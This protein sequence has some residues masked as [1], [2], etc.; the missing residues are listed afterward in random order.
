[1]PRAG[2]T[3][4]RVVHE[5]AELADARGLDGLSLSALADRL[6][7][8]VPSLYKHV[9]S[10]DEVQRGV[11][12]LGIRELAAELRAA[13]VG[14]AGRDALAGCAAA[15]RSYARR[16]PGRY[17]A[18]QRV[19][20]PDAPEWLAAANDLVG[21]VFAVLR[22]YGLEDEDVVHVTRAVR[23][24]LHGFVT[25][26]LMGAFGLPEDVDASFDRLV[27]LLDT[28]L[29]GQPVRTRR[30]RASMKQ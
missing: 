21:V 26:E 9:G 7:V 23:S 12:V 29:S 25:L 1:V 5:A 3:P 4:E 22:G 30:S 17:L 19:P 6:G 20:D 28:G 8:R 13:T 10:L 15:Y 27:E 18:M 11:A 14:L 16:H 24:A 2:L